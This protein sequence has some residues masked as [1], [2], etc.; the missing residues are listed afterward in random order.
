MNSKPRF[1]PPAWRSIL[2][3]SALALVSAIALSVFL[4]AFHSNSLP[5]GAAKYAFATASS[6]LGFVASA[7]AF[8]LSLA[9]KGRVCLPVALASFGLGSLWIIS[10]AYY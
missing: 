1:A 5:E 9:G 7:L 3:F 10:W 8:V 4:V 2:A 6:R